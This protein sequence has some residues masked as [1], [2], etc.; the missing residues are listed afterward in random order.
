[1]RGIVYVNQVQNASMPID[2]PKDV[3]NENLDGNSDIN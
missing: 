3:P 1:M 2:V